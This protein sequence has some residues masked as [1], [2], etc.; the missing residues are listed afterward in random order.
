[1]TQLKRRPK[2]DKTRDLRLRLLVHRLRKMT[3]GV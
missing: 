1:M 2:K 3:K